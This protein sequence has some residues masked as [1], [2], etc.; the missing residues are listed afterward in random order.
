MNLVKTELGQGNISLW[1][2]VIDLGKP[3][4]Q[5][6]LEYLLMPI[7]LFVW[8]LPT[9]IGFTIAVILKALIGALG[10]YFWLVDLKVR[11]SVAVIVGVVYAFSTW[12]KSSSTGVSLPKN[13]P[14]CSPY[15]RV[16]IDILNHT[17]K[18]VKKVHRWY[19]RGH[20]VYTPLP[21][22]GAAS[23]ILRRILVTSSG[24]RGVGSLPM[25]TKPVT[26]GVLRTTY[27]DSSERIIFTNM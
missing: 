26:P 18:I 6:S 2:D 8:I 17:A 9:D 12:T 16:L 21:I 25:P 27:Q 1:S 7:Y 24:R 23:S 5:T 14:H 10:M 13:W 22:C 15:A 3:L 20:H 4:I 19:A 11:K